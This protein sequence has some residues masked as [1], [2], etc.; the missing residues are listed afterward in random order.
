MGTG[1]EEDVEEPAPAPS[2]KKKKKKKPADYGGSEFGM[3]G[4]DDDDDNGV[5]GL[6]PQASADAASSSPRASVRKKKKKPTD[7]GGSEFGMMGDEDDDDNGVEGLPP[8]AASS[9]SPSSVRKKKKKQPNLADQSS[10]FGGMFGG[11]DDGDGG[12]D[13]G[14]ENLP[15]YVEKKRRKRRDYIEKQD[16][17]NPLFPMEGEG[18]VDGPVTGLD[19]SQAPD[20]SALARDQYI[21]TK[22]KTDQLSAG[23][24]C[25]TQY[26]APACRLA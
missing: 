13:G 24:S 23:E 5:E 21:S 9:S 3:M 11:D 16:M 10:E 26:I 12:D 8:Q 14:I 25:S 7:Y 6:P 22:K 17:D 18:P 1:K 4:G 2:P 15:E 19:P 20:R